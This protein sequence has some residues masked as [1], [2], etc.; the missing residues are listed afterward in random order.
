MK[1]GE[2][3]TE[4]DYNTEAQSIAMK[5][6]AYSGSGRT[7]AFQALEAARKEDYDQATDLLKR[8]NDEIAKAHDVQT[9]LLV[10]EA[11]GDKTPFS[12]LLIHAQ[13]HFMT[14]MLA[15][16]LITEMVHMYKGFERKS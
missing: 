3:M 11:N 13:D 14:S 1:A 4:T 8:S 10:G 12:I 2:I 7:L 6:I 16:E 9:N 5:I 15:N